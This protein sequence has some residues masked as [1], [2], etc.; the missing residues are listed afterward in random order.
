LVAARNHGHVSDLPAAAWTMENV[1]APNVSDKESVLTL[2]R[3][4]IDAYYINETCLEWDPVKN[5]IT[6]GDDFGWNGDGLRGHV[7]ADE[8]NSTIV[9]SFKGTSKA[10]WDN[11]GT[12]TN[13]K[14]NDNIFSSC[15]CGQQGPPTWRRVCSCAI[16]AYTCNQTCLVETMREDSRYYAASRNIYKNVTMLYPNSNIW[17]VG[18]SL[19]GTV[20]GLLGL[21]YGVP[22]VTF[23]AVPDALAASRLGIPRPPVSTSARDMT[24]I[25]H[26][27][28]TADPIYMGKCNTWTSLCSLTGYAFQSECHTGKRCVYDV[29]KDKGWS[30]DLRTHGLRTVINNIITQYDTVPE[31]IADAQCV[32]CYNWNYVEGN[33][34]STITSSKK[35]TATSSTL[36]T[37]TSSTL[38]CKT[39]G[40]WGC[41]DKETSRTTTASTS[42]VTTTLQTT[43]TVTSCTSLG[44]F[45][46]CYDSTQFQRQ[47]LIAVP[48]ATRIMRDL[49]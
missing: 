36:L 30:L 20:S 3:M 28:H 47:I 15:C 7:F 43:T 24:G 25:S 32:D 31:C 40:W 41:L 16:S 19:G 49:N 8:N 5:N 22:A 29:V 2:A 38:T 34:S 45:G 42:V 6:R 44:W 13:D 11:Q 33:S 35:L 48:T 21:T 46:R 12:E 4:A 37:S 26:I 17:L 23:E 9:I 10:W 27:G 39:R 14:E 1:L 18:H